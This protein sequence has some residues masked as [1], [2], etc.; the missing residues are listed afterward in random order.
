MDISFVVVT[1]GQRKNKTDL[2][3]KS[4]EYQ[5]IPN[6]E[7]IVCG[8]Y[9]K[10]KNYQLIKD[11]LSA[12][13]GLLGSMRNQGSERSKYENITILDD[14]MLL[15]LDWYENLKKYGNEFDLLTSKVKL[16]DGTRFWDHT[17]F[18]SPKYGHIILED[19]E[20][21]DF[22]YTSGGQA[23]VM[24]KYVFDKVKWSKEYSTGERATMKNLS[25]YRHGKQNED[26][27]FSERCRDAG[28][29]IKHNPSMLSFHDDE[30][31]TSIGRVVR[32][33]KAKLTYKW[34]KETDYYQPPSEAAAFADHLRREGNEAESVDLLRYYLKRHFH[35]FFLMSVYEQFTKQ[36]QPDLKD[37]EFNENGDPTYNQIKNK[38][39]K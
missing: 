38:L 23:W 30:K 6:Y 29:K 19:S 34:V 13:E 20:N 21:D 32:E 24:K 26:T 36:Y 15:S 35:N 4:I 31:Y 2:L 12:S 22:L 11:S 27:D 5:K 14:D 10:G 37:I 9:E 33:R 3:I 28:F 25:D 17:C 8:K 18:R 16:P 7:I 1:N 39:L